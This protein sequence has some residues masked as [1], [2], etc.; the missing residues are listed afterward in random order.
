MSLWRRV[1][2]FWAILQ[3]ARALKRQGIDPAEFFRRRGM[4]K[5]LEDAHR[6]EA[7]V[8]GEA[9]AVWQDYE[10]DESAEAGEVTAAHLALIRRARFAWNAVEAGAPRLDPARPYGSADPL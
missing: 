7:D 3:E 1:S 6:I 8:P 10:P 4:E 9:R 2:H 5:A